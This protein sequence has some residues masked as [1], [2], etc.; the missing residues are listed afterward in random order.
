MDTRLAP[1]TA[2][3]PSGWSASRTAP[4]PALPGLPAALTLDTRPGR[5]AG[6]R[7]LFADLLQRSREPRADDPRRLPAA[8][9]P[10]PGAAADRERVD[11]PTPVRE[12]ERARAAEQRPPPGREPER[13]RDPQRVRE[14]ERPREA[15]GPRASRADDAPRA[16]AREPADSPA[17]AASDRAAGR[18]GVRRPGSPGARAGTGSASGNGQVAPGGRPSEP[19]VGPDGAF[20]EAGPA[21]ARSPRRTGVASS[22]P[23]ADMPAPGALPGLPGP[24]TGPDGR[25]VGATDGVGAAVTATG[26]SPAA[27]S[28]GAADRGPAMGAPTAPEGLPLSTVGDNPAGAAAGAETD[29][30]LR[31]ALPLAGRAGD[32]ATRVG[33]PD[34]I[35]RVDAA[36][37]TTDGAGA[38]PAG[39][40]FAALA[41]PRTEAPTAFATANAAA[42]VAPG[43][44]VVPAPSVNG[45]IGSEAL[46]SVS[47]T[48]DAPVD[49][50]A[51]APAMAAQV[52][53]LARDGVQRAELRLNPVELGP[54][55]VQIMLD[56]TQARIDFV[57]DSA[58]TRQSIEGG[59]PTLAS[60]LREA[61]LTLAGGGVF[62]QPRD[63]R[64]D[65]RG[66]EDDGAGRGLR[67]E[68]HAGPT[69]PGAP[70]LRRPDPGR[71]LD[72][73]A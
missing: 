57:A 40:G 7:D 18:P 56:G 23:V 2:A 44:G 42:T 53:M 24:S 39:A 50:P 20:A 34:V 30:R 62:Q 68:L 66:R 60:A 27:G 65:A 72:V 32:P 64:G 58:Q 26:A 59:L 15:E 1:G 73:Y 61:G 22:D 17:T 45:P 28:V 63:S 69:V 21:E 19:A 41:A 37:V 16:E 67:V 49:S 6:G 13:P 3:Q 46:A 31:P 38:E 5:D 29:V 48:V 8:S 11:P 52:T 25:L 47:A 70:G 10:A 43:A 14:R 33:R 36:A 4:T 51:F 9:T 71:A 35:D 55:A 54:V 12:A